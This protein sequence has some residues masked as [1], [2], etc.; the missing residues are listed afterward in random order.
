MAD[1]I[2]KAAKNPVETIEESLILALTGH[3]Y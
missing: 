3:L 1:K 2:N